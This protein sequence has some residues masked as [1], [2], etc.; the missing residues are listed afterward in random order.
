MDR[1]LNTGGD[2][3]S[4]G[5]LSNGTVAVFAASLGA[6]NLQASLPVRTDPSKGLISARL[7]ISDVTDLQ[8]TVTKAAANETKVQNISA[9][10]GSTTVTGTLAATSVNSGGHN[11]LTTNGGGVTGSLTVGGSAVLTAAGGSTLTT[12]LSTNQE[13]VQRHESGE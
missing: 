4:N 13:T 3:S 6:E 8:S 9:T 1:F 5:D 7:S 12:T 2:G 10:S 11:V